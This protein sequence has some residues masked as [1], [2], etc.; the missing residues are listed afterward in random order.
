MDKTLLFQLLAT[1]ELNE[2]FKTI[3]KLH[4]SIYSSEGP[5]NSEEIKKICDTFSNMEEFRC[6]IDAWDVLR[7]AIDGL[8]KLLY[9]KLFLYRTSKWEYGD[10]WK[11]D[12]HSGF[13]LCSLPVIAK[14]C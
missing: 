1:R 8:S 6:R 9:M 14:Y 5:L 3:K 10:Q 4:I 11:E 12:H 13:D 7:A 2:R